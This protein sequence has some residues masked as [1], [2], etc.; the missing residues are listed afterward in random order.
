[1]SDQDIYKVLIDYIRDDNK[2]KSDLLAR[3][4]SIE[5]QTKLTNGRMN[6]IEPVVEGLQ[7]LNE[8]AA[9]TRKINWKWILGI[10]AVIEFCF[11]AAFYLFMDWLK[12]RIN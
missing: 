6:K 11:T 3:V 5:A 10:L 8:T 1:M 7:K 2:W 4:G 12:N 9:V